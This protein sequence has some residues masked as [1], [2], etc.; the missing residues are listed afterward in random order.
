MVIP[1]ENSVGI[2]LIWSVSMVYLMYRTN[3][4]DRNKQLFN[5]MLTV[6]FGVILT[7]LGHKICAVIPFIVIMSIVIWKN[8]GGMN[9]RGS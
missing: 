2:L 7:M 5:I 1:I 4:I 3:I 8:I 6:V 9:V